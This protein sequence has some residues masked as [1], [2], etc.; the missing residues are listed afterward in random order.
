MIL[1]KKAHFCQLNLKY[2]SVLEMRTEQTMK[3]TSKK[4]L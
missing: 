2:I 1:L 4:M 3:K